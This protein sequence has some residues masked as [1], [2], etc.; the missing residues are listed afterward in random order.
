MKLPIDARA[1]Y[2]RLVTGGTRH[3]FCLENRGQCSGGRLCI[4]GQVWNEKTKTKAT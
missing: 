3:D 4:Q 2:L 1:V